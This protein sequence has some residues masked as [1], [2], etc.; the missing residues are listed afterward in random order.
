MT[1]ILVTAMAALA[2]LAA[3]FVLKLPRASVT[4]FAA[5]LLFG[6]AGYAV[7]GSAGQ[8]STPGQH[9]DEEVRIGEAM[10]E[11]RRTLYDTGQPPARFL[12]VA[13]A[14]AR[15]GQFENAARILRGAVAENPQDA[16]SWTAL[17]N[18]LVEHA[19]G[20]LTPAA[21]EAYSRAQA[22]G[23]GNP[24]AGYFL[25]V[26][27]L[28]NGKPL[29]ARALWVRMLEE[30]PEDAPWREDLELRIAALD[31]L[32]ARVEAQAAE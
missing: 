5:A 17:G 6:L 23:R 18:A 9:N 2:L 25:G 1:W 28:R 32:I 31:D 21:I 4:M 22:A 27:L 30:A 24:G 14:F 16:E 19:D 11:A 8:P 7:Q 13:D 15:R 20:Q 12:T 10:V 26:A 29:E 3:V